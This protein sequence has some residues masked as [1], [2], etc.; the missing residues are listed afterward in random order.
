MGSEL[1]VKR[2]RLALPGMLAWMGF[3]ASLAQS[4]Q[5]AQLVMASEFRWGMHAR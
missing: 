3:P 2:G 1:R 4:G 5:P